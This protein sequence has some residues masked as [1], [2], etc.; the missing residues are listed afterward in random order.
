VSARERAIDALTTHRHGERKEACPHC[1]AFYGDIVDRVAGI[2]AAEALREAARHFEYEMSQAWG[3]DT[4][5][6]STGTHV[7]DL[8]AEILRE[9]AADAEEQPS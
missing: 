3:G 8:V 4:R 5:W 1:A 6:I 9:C 2:L 7:A